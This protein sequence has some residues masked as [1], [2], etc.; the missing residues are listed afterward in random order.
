MVAPADRCSD[1]L[2]DVSPASGLRRIDEMLGLGN[3]LEIRVPERSVK[4]GGHHVGGQ[5][6]YVVDR[7]S[8]KLSVIKGTTVTATISVGNRPVDVAVDVSARTVYVTNKGDN[9]LSVIKY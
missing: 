6:V 1:E 5:K 9:T 7:S 2:D 3:R 4:V 8:N